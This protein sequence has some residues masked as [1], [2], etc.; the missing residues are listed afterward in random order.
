MKRGTLLLLVLCAFSAEAQQIT[1]VGSCSGPSTS[2]WIGESVT[3]SAAEPVAEVGDFVESV[4]PCVDLDLTAQDVRGKPPLTRTWTLPSGAV[5]SGNPARINTRDLPAGLSEIRY[6]LSNAFGS[7]SISIVVA[8]QSL[9]FTTEPT[10]TNH[11]ASTVSFDAK[12][13]G[14]TEWHWSW[15]DGT[16]TGWVSGCGGLRPVK[17]YA[18]S[19]SYTVTVSARN[20]RQGAISRTFQVVATAELAPRV[21]VFAA[22]GCFLDVFCTFAPGSPILFEQVVSGSPD[23]LRLR[24]ERRWLRRSNL[25]NARDLARL[26]FFRALYARGLR[27]RPSRALEF[28]PPRLAPHCP[29]GERPGPHRPSEPDDRHRRYRRRRL[30][31]WLLGRPRAALGG[32]ILNRDWLSSVGSTRLR[33]AIRPSELP[34]QQLRGDPREHAVGNARPR[35]PLPSLRHGVQWRR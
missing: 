27:R 3:L 25:L 5:V 26:R 13:V 9:A 6:T 11:G 18:A 28:S 7:D 22:K 14:A 16:S 31:G 29:T 8:V 24:L 20:C 4:P 23:E 21:L 33:V 34:G 12:T 30:G 19:G 17:T 10:W 2:F 35:T 32:Q 15:G 1:G